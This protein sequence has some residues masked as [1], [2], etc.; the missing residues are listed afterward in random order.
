MVTSMKLKGVFTKAI[1]FCDSFLTE[2]QKVN[3]KFKNATFE[4]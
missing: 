4:Q 2:K 1:Q 3:G